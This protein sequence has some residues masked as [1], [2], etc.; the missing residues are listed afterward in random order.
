MNTRANA[1]ICV[2]VS[3]LIAHTL[4]SFYGMYA[5]CNV[6]KATAYSSGCL[7]SACSTGWRVSADNA[8]CDPNICSC[9]NGAP[10]T[11]AEC[12]THGSNICES[13][14]TGFQLDAGTSSCIGTVLS[15][16]CDSELGPVRLCNRISY[17]YGSV[18]VHNG[19]LLACAQSHIILRHVCRL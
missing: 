19:G 15:N 8:Q 14:N 13:C 12:T 7:V 1:P 17:Q 18:C 9:E 11:G 6:D 16:R 2:L 5:G 10:V 4:T 3:V